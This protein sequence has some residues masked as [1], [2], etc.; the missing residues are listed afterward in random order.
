M[1]NDAG[2]LSSVDRALQLILLLR[3][4]GSLS[5]TEAAAE[6]DVTPP[7][8]YRLL[9]SLKK[10]EF[11]TQGPNRHYRPGPNLAS[12][13]R[14]TLSPNVLR[15]LLRPELTLAQSLTHETVNLWMLEGVYVRNFD[16]IESPQALA[17]RVNAYDRIPA[18]C[19]AAGKCLLGA[20]TNQE[21]EQMHAQGLPRWRTDRISSITS[22]KRHLHDVRQ[23]GYAVNTEEAA[24]GVSGVGAAVYA[25]DGSALVALSCGVPQSR[26]SPSRA[27]EL[28]EIIVETAQAMSKKIAE[29]EL[30]PISG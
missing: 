8:A 25:P 27:K 24:Q 19:S 12:E 16:G 18:Y 14:T 7:T 29:Q 28:A 23:R 20:L 9:A 4:R 17:I 1:R 5:V 6:L 2:P 26:F 11:A 22:L 10:R 13:A 3:E 30:H 15:K 21:V